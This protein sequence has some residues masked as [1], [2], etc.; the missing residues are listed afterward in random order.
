MF[1]AKVK[2]TTQMVRIRLTES[3]LDKEMVFTKD[4]MVNLM[5]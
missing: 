4:L 5:S 2:T 3:I 1:M